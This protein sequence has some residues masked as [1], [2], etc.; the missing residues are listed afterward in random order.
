MKENNDSKSDYSD[1]PLMISGTQAATIANCKNG[2]AF[3]RWARAHNLP[4]IGRDR[5]SRPA[6][7]KAVTKLAYAHC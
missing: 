3:S 1:L 5:W 6:V 4:K 2:K 7:V